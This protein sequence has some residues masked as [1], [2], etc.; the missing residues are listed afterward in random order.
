MLDSDPRRVGHRLVVGR[1]RL[2]MGA[3]SGRQRYGT[4]GY[5]SCDPRTVRF[6]VNEPPSQGGLA[7]VR[8]Q[9]AQHIE[10]VEGPPLPPLT[11]P[12][13]DALLSYNATL[14]AL[15]Q[16]RAVTLAALCRYGLVRLEA[17][18]PGQVGGWWTP[19]ERGQRVIR[20][21]RRAR[22]A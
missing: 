18:S 6:K 22:A 14:N 19:T 21:L 9:H 8:G 16:G 1:T 15:T 10:A 3:V 2:G 7:V 20:L 13:T 17:P 5:C 4:A 12:Q 11:R